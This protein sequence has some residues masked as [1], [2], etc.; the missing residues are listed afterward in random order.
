MGGSVKDEGTFFSSITEYFS[1]PPQVPL[2]AAQY[3]A[4]INAFFGSNAPAVLA[5]YPISN[6]NNDPELAY[7]RAVTDGLLK[8]SSLHVLKAQAAS[9]TGNG[10]YGYDF[11]YQN[12]PYY[13]PKM[14]NPL[15]PTGNFQPLAAHTI[16]IQFLFV[17]WHGGQLGVNLA[18]DSASQPR[19]LQGP[20]L[21]LSSQLVAAW[22]N[23]TKTGNPNGTGAPVWP[24]FTPTS[25]VFLQ[26][27]IPNSNETEAQYRANYKCD[28]WDSLPPPV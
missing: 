8:C 18:Q 16:D 11:T 28:F 13:F 6:Y 20:E 7:D 14:P 15:S 26:E 19:E 22:T 27:D 12:A 25:S 23:F 24:V 1:G 4:N 3:V 17:D 9:N 10:V 2:T 21:T 5:E